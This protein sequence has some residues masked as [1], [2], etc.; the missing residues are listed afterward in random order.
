MDLE[1]PMIL[2]DSGTINYQQILGYCGV[3]HDDLCEW[4]SVLEW[5][6]TSER[7]VKT[8]SIIFGEE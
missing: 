5:F 6:T 4:F 7:L 1:F 3:Y 8:G 2:V